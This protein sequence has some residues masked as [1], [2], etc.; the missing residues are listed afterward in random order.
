MIRWRAP[1]WPSVSLN[2]DGARKGL[3][4]AGAGGLLRDFNGN[5]IKGF[6]VNLGTCS[7]LSAELW[8]LLHGLKMAWENGFR[9]VQVGVDNKSVVQLLK[10]DSVSDT[11]NAALIKTIRELLERDWSVHLEH[12]YREANYAADFLASYSLNSPIG[13]HVL[14]SP[15][16]EIVG[17]LCKDAYGIAHPRLVLS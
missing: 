6:I 7:V 15:P 13:L 4:Q 2:T 14:N 5:W 8:G 9:R 12:V 3:E 17:I 16:T 1:D 11:E 10:M